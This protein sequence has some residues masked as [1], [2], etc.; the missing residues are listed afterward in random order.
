[1]PFLSHAFELG[2]LHH[3]F[4]PP[5]PPSSPAL[6]TTSQLWRNDALLRTI[7]CMPNSV[8]CVCRCCTRARRLGRR[9]LQPSPLQPAS[10]AFIA[11]TM[12]F[13]YSHACTDLQRFICS[14]SFVRVQC[15]IQKLGMCV[16]QARA[17]R[18]RGREGRGEGCGG[19]EWKGQG[20]VAAVAAAAAA[21]GAAADTSV[22]TSAAAATA[23]A[24]AA[25]AASGAAA[26]RAFT[27][28]DCSNSAAARA[29]CC[30]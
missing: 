18:V 20:A 25:A 7:R 17:S 27:I 13:L 24:T 2:R 16:C 21:T 26:A 5:P 12:Q 8:Y 1:M 22:G 3:E 11:R 15:L 10:H 19:K 14:D 23:A 29:P 6:Q 28:Y 30:R 4:A 9:Q